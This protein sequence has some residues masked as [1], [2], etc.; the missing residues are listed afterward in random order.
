[1][2]ERE[3]KGIRCY[4]RVG[5]PTITPLY[6][7]TS[8][9]YTRVPIAKPRAQC[10]QLYESATE[11]KTYFSYMTKSS[12]S[13]SFTEV[14][15]PKPSSQVVALGLFKDYFKVKTGVEWE[16]RD[17][18]VDAQEKPTAWAPWKYAGPGES[19]TQSQE[20]LVQADSTV[21]VQSH[22]DIEW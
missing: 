15:A 6:T 9:R 8:P 1:M 12:P 14:V 16:K 11:P 19:P 13:G 3:G 22:D 5:H 7:Y 4:L 20:D 21:T 2:V 10:L 17:V 18:D